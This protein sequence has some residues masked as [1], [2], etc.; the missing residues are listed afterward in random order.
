MGFGVLEITS[1]PSTIT[2]LLLDAGQL[3]VDS[4]NVVNTLTLTGSSTWIA[5][6]IGGSGAGVGPSQIVVAKGGSLTVPGGGLEPQQRTQSVIVNQG[7]LNWTGGGWCLLGD[8]VINDGTFNIRADGAQMYDCSIQSPLPGPAQVVNDAGGSIVRTSS[9]GASSSIN[10]PGGLTN[11]GTV[12]VTSGILTVSPSYTSSKT[13]VFQPH[14]AGPAPG[15]GFGQMLVAGTLTLDGAVNPITASGF[16]PTNQ[17]AF[18]VII[19]RVCGSQKFA[20]SSGPYTEQYNPGDVTLIYNPSV[21]ALNP[22]SLDFGQVQV[23]TTKGPNAVTLVNIG[24]IPLHVAGVGLVGRDAGDF[25]V[26]PNNCGGATLATNASCSVS[27]SFFP[28]ATGARSAALSFADDAPGSP[29]SSSLAGTGTPGPTP[30]TSPSATASPTVLS[31]TSQPTPSSTKVTPT[32]TA[33]VRLTPTATVMPTFSESPTPATVTTPTSPPGPDADFIALSVQGN[34]YGPAG[35]GLNA[36]VHRYPTDCKEVFFFFDQTRIGAA[37]VDAT[38]HARA[39]GISVPGDAKPGG[40]TVSSSCQSSGRVIELSVSFRVTRGEHRTAFVTSLNQPREISFTLRSVGVSAAIALGVLVL[41]GFPAQVFNSTLQEHYEEVRRWFH[42]ERPLS[43]VVQR[44]DQRVLFPI[45]LAVGGT[46]YALLT[47][48]V[49]LNRSTL[50]LVVGLGMAVAITTVGF[51]LPSFFYF[52]TRFR[53]RGKVLVLPGTVLVAAAC[54]GLSRLLHFQPGYLYGLLAV[55]VF[56]HD[57]DKETA[58]RLAGSSAAIVLLLAIVAWVARVPVAGAAMGRTGFW[59]LVL[60]AALS[61][62]FLIGLESV[63]V[64]LLPMRFLDG[65][66]IQAWSK[67]A[68]AVLFGVAAFTLVEV[69]LMPGSGYVGHTTTVGRFTVLSIYIAFALFTAGFW[70]YFRFRKARPE[71][72]LET[73]GDF[74]VR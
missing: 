20:S 31:G 7:T 22:P 42:L 44:V 17:Q 51:A 52:E 41:L 8:G 47:P 29:Q 56:H 26:G 24:G 70:A 38:G 61:G 2:K 49:G 30:T 59:W 12:D 54:V 55:F 37:R 14:I 40:H 1:M 11:R 46:L 67:I 19:C 69:L 5:G 36:T 9:A 63:L 6:S 4:P 50:A 15:T 35:I 32:P 3:Q 60:E 45:F 39:G 27:V 48:D 73:E 58:G 53:D 68:W 13:A 23:G 28:S 33:T 43:E 25:R 10:V 18:R 62:T 65:S 16:V 72:E 57:P 34:A 21:A 64:G 71:E 66:K 74:G